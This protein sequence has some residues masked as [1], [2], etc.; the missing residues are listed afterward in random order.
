MALALGIG[1]LFN[2]SNSP[3]VSYTLDP[4]TDS[5]R[6]KTVRDVDVDEELCIFYGHK[7]WFKPIEA[8][9]SAVDP[10][11]EDGWGGLSTVE[12]DEQDEHREDVDPDE[13]VDDDS[14]PFTR[15]KPPPDEEDLES[16]RTVPAWVV[17]VP[18]PRHIT[19]LLKWLKKAGLEDPS[20]GHLKRIRKQNDRTTLLFLKTTFWPTFYAPKRKGET[21][22]WSYGKVKWA[23]DAIQIVIAEAMKARSEGELPI[24]AFVPA[25][26][27]EDGDRKTALARDTR[28]S[29]SHPLRHAAL[30]L[31]RR[32]ADLQADRDSSSENGSNYL[33]TSKTVFLSHEPCIMCSM[34]LLHSRVKEVFYLIP[35]SKT[36]GCGGV[37]CLPTL[38][39][40]NHRFEICV[41][42][43]TVPD[44]LIN[45]SLDA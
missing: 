19:T 23:R 29:A 28:T 14:L 3:N 1:S 43:E 8:I 20:L 34:A 39:G 13:I 37:A 7:L 10:E 38:Q 31:V 26:Y 30:N 16:V 33:L 21:E 44:L 25:C 32:V 18:E 41:W 6:Y 24:S 36:G 15:F 42:N 12:T 27:G 35:M 17:D 45:E 22:P 5:I 2:H 11:S 4:Q 40:V 9:P